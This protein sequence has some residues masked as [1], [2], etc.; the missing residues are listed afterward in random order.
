M[1][2]TTSQQCP[3]CISSSDPPCFANTLAPFSARP[4][5]RVVVW[6]RSLCPGGKQA[7]HASRHQHTQPT[8]R[9]ACCSDAPPT[10]PPPPPCAGDIEGEQ[11]EG[12]RSQGARLQSVINACPPSGNPR[13]PR[14]ARGFHG[15][16]PLPGLRV[17]RGALH[18]SR[19][20]T[21]QA[22]GGGGEFNASSIHPLPHVASFS[23]PSPS[24]A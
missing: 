10:P 24:L 23:S 5:A 7:K 12:L 9:Q 17:R 15:P 4:R 20:G 6:W 18:R 1:L 22:S 11:H 13:R 16:P 14:G 21:K 2:H 19:R 8:R 3:L